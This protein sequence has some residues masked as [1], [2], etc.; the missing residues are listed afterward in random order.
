MKFFSP[1]QYQEMIA[2]GETV[3]TTSEDIQWGLFRVG[4]L[5]NGDEAPVEATHLGSGLDKTWI[6]RSSVA[7]WVLD[8]AIER[9]WVGK[10]PYICNK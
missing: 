3:S 5:T 4:G 7:R 8:E 1:G 2:I 6:S 10:M 9:K